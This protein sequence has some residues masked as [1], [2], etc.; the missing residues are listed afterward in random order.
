VRRL[1]LAA[2]A[3]SLLALPVPGRAAGSCAVDLEQRNAWHPL[4]GLGAVAM[5]DADPC[6]LLVVSERSGVSVSDDGG[7]STRRVGPAPTPPTRLVAAGLPSGRALLVGQDGSLWRTGDRGAHWS[8]S[9]GL[10]GAVR[11]VVV[12]E[13]RPGHL[14]AVVAPTSPLPSVAVPV[15]PPVAVGAALYESTDGGASFSAVDDATGL[16][17]TA[18]AFDAV[19]TDRWWLGVGGPAGGLFV[20]TDGGATFSPVARGDVHDLAT[21][22]LA[23]GGSEVV[24]ATADGLL[25]SRDGGNSVTTKLAG[26]AVDELALEWHHPS[27]ALLLAGTVRRTSD[28]GGTARGQAT[29]LPADCSP[30][31]LRRDRSVP[32]VF[33]VG[34]ADGRTWRYRSDGTDLTST[35]WPDNGSGSLL[36]GAPLPSTPMRVLRRLTITNSRSTAD[37]S[38]AFDGTVLYYTDHNLSGRVHRMLASTGAALP[39]LRIGV[40]RAIGHVA[41][42]AN[43]DALLVLDK[44]FVVWSVSLRTGAVTKLFHAPLS[45]RSE[46][47]DAETDQF[48]GAMSYD[49]ATDRLLFANDQSDSFY[50]YDREGRERHACPS[51]GLP[52]LITVN[53]SNGTG[54][55][56]SIAGL[57]ATGDG[58]VYVEAEDDSTVVRIDRSCHVLAQYTH[59]FFTEATNENDALACDTTTFDEPA[60]WLRDAQH[61]RIVAFSVDAGYCALPSGVSVTAPD[62][63]ATGGSGRVCATLRSRAKGTPLPGQHVD[64]L[65]AGRGI[66]SPVTDRHGRACT[67]YVPLAAEAGAGT[68]SSTAR[69]PVLAA[70]LGTPAYRPASARASLLVSR[71]VVPPAPPPPPVEAQP[72]APAVVAPPPPPPPVQPP[73][74]PPPAPQQAP[75]A[76]GHPGAQPGAMGQL[77]AATMPEDEAEAAAQGADTHLMTAVDWEAYAL[78]SAF[79]V[80]AFA[81]VLR[82]RR[83]S[84]VR[85]QSA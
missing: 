78:P 53:G 45:G 39:D 56:A 82:R 31:E 80:V 2:A 68:A 85:S 23:G 8:K 63:V 34:C 70:F 72:A 18:A 27:A 24:A 83:A 3:L 84:R 54:N 73:Q 29:G 5:E 55:R 50:E 28:A 65:V 20:T 46:D 37:G 30:H 7:R 57:V 35:D 59:E 47:D 12:E 42:D 26:T 1:V 10:T 4:A 67:D 69:Q 22:A 77:G 13:A 6:R 44:A 66:G 33:L 74:P 51:L 58:L 48:Y 19:V 11:D 60:V 62:S 14:L 49:S 16:A 9:G 40:T 21:S 38:I 17:V 76:Q 75:V 79:G 52:S 81:A 32:S 36:P 71:A 41:Y 15:A 64:L 61:M 25:V 43:R